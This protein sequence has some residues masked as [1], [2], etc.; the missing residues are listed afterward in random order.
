MLVETD[1]P[2]LAPVP[3]RGQPNRPAWVKVVGEAVAA[4]AGVAVEAVEGA[5]WENTASVFG[6][7]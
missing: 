6:L 4:A 5:T 1:A 7:P 3:H 2:F